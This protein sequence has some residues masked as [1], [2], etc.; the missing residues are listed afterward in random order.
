MADSETYSMTDK[1]QRCKGNG[2]S[3]VEIHKSSSGATK[4]SPTICPD[5]AGTGLRDGKKALAAGVTIPP[6]YGARLT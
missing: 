5:C 1:C 4:P 2:L 3:E 6:G